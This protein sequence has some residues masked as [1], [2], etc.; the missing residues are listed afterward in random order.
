[1]EQIRK[2]L[3]KSRVNSTQLK[4]KALSNHLPF[5]SNQYTQRACDERNKKNLFV[6]KPNV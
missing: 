2:K 4:E 1:M 6:L 3:Q 5:I